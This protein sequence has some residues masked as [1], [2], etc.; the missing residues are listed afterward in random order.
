MIH[1]ILLDYRDSGDYFRISVESDRD[2][3]DILQYL[4]QY[5]HDVR[6]WRSYESRSK[7]DRGTRVT[8]VGTLVSCAYFGTKIGY[9]MR[10]QDYKLKSFIDSTPDERQNFCKQQ[11]SCRRCQFHTKETEEIFYCNLHGI[12]MNYN[13][14][15]EENK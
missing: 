14:L 9:N 3:H 1:Q 5:S 10:F 13:D 4:Q 12:Y 15:R 11:V 2:T 6:Y 7:Q 8:P